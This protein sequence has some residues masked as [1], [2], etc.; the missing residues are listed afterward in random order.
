V[1]DNEKALF[2]PSDL[3]LFVD[4]HQPTLTQMMGGGKNE[5][6]YAPGTAIGGSEEKESEQDDVDDRVSLNDNDVEQEEESESSG[7]KE[8]K[9]GAVQSPLGHIHRQSWR[10]GNN[11]NNDSTLIGVGVWAAATL[12][13]QNATSPRMNSHN[14]A[15]DRLFS[16][17]LVEGDDG[18]DELLDLFGTEVMCTPVGDEDPVLDGSA[19]ERVTM[20]M[21]SPAAKQLADSIERQVIATNSKFAG[22]EAVC[23]NWRE[24]IRFALIQQDSCDV[25]SALQQVR[26]SKAKLERLKEQVMAAWKRQEAVLELYEMSLTESMKR[27]EERANDDETETLEASTLSQAQ[28]VVDKDNEEKKSSGV[29]MSQE[30]CVE[31]NETMG[32]TKKVLSPIE[33]VELTSSQLSGDAVHTCSREAKDE[34][35]REQAKSIFSLLSP[36]IH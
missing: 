32:L 16:D 28:A 20:S 10:D 25:E 27:L 14:C 26:Q 30:A 19:L 35:P 9:S 3:M 11:S 7:S 22:M 6:Q 15:W 17:N 33:E 18:V 36:G 29:S 5:E 4:Y 34:V 2:P 13:A 31:I 12:T 23:P 8:L 1:R 21:L 24:N